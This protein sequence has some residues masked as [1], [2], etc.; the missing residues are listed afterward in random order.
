MSSAKHAIAVLILSAAAG[1][2]MWQKLQV[3]A[4]I[5]IIATLAI[6]YRGIARQF[7]DAVLELARH[8]T[9]AK[10]GNLEVQIDKKFE[11]LSGLV[12]T[13]VGWVKAVASRLAPEHVGLLLQIQRAGR[14]AFPAGVRTQLR[15][16]R[17]SGLIEHNA[18]SL[19]ESTEVWLSKAGEEFVVGIADAGGLP[20]QT[21]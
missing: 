7:L 16:L 8:A 18:P 14:Y 4:V 2:A 5:A 11:T 9:Q 10:W 6:L 20:T 13:R 17:N 21:A 12:S 1:Y 19:G 15:V 3:V